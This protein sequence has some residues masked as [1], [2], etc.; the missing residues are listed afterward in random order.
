M[1]T[2]RWVVILHGEVV[3]WTVAA[4]SSAEAIAAVRAK[5]HGGPIVVRSMGWFY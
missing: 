2:Q 5:G 1:K 3:G 4:P